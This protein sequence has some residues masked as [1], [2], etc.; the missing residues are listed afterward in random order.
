M[1]RVQV[2]AGP[3]AQALPRWSPLPVLPSGDPRPPVPWSLS[4]TVA[5]ERSSPPGVS[6]CFPADSQPLQEAQ[7]SPILSLAASLAPHPPGDKRLTLVIPTHPLQPHHDLHVYAHTHTHT[8][9]SRTTHTGA[10]NPTCHLGRASP[11]SQTLPWRRP[12]CPP[13]FTE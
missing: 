4:A 5:G 12:G 8:T 13:T 11:G 3:V 1:V 2:T 9:C 10:P 7:G 6:I